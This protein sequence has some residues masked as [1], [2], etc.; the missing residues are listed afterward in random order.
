MGALFKG[1]L[2]RWADEGGGV[3][4]REVFPGLQGVGAGDGDAGDALSDEEV[5][6]I[7][8]SSSSSSSSAFVEDLSSEDEDEDV[9]NNL[10]PSSSRAAAAPT[11]ALP[12]TSTSTAS[13]PTS[14]M[15]GTGSPESRL[16]S[17][18][19]SLISGFSDD[20]CFCPNHAALSHRWRKPGCPG[21]EDGE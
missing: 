1:I 17:H 18:R 11:A 10:D 5:L 7:F 12:E 8:S 9:S 4:E 21:Y 3:V 13:I 16:N 19:M 14:T 6:S 2:R 15:T 20:F